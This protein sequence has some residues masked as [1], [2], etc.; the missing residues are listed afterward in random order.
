[1]IKFGIIGTSWITEEFIRCAKL[2]ADFKV[3][4]VYSRSEEKAQLFAKKVGA[5][6]IF[7]NLKTMAESDLI[8]AVYIASPNSLH[9]EQAILFL[10]HKKHVLCEKS[11]AANSAEMKEIIRAAKSNQVAFME[12]LKTTFEP[13]MRAIKANLSKLGKIRRYFSSYCQYSSRYDAYKA[14]TYNNTFNP[15]FANGALMDLG[16][17]CIYPLVYLFGK[18]DQILASAIKLDSGVDGQTT[19]ICQYADMDAVL[20]FSKITA[21]T[22]PSEIQGEAATLSFYSINEIEEVTIRYNDIKTAKEELVFDPSRDYMYYETKAFI[23]MIQQNKIE[24]SENTFQ[25]ALDVRKLMDEVRKQ[26]GLVF[27][28]DKK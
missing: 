25:L 9:A 3:N 16:V 22:V 2:H 6:H 10:N 5:D 27:P 21:S 20:M 24:S 26:I 11:A 15:E 17:Y 13:G 18:P 4:A 8:D 12:A 23:E 28:N 7:T 1:M 14:G 19:V